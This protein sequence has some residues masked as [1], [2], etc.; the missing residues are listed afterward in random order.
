MQ[1]ATGFAAMCMQYL[2]VIEEG[3]RRTRERIGFA[4]RVEVWRGQD[5]VIQGRLSSSPPRI[6]VER[7][8]RVDFVRTSADGGQLELVFEGTPKQMR[9]GD[10]GG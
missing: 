8:P 7:R 6:P 1:L 10:K 9:D 2:P 4:A 3:V 5:G